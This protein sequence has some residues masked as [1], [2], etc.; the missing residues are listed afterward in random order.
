VSVVDLGDDT[1]V[2]AFTNGGGQYS[3]PYSGTVIGEYAVSTDTAGNVIFPETTI[4][5][6]M[7]ADGKL[8]V[9]A[10]NNK[11]VDALDVSSRFDLSNTSVV[12]GAYANDYY[13]GKCYLIKD[14]HPILPAGDDTSS[15]EGSS[16]EPE[17]RGEA[18]ISTNKLTALGLNSLDGKCSPS[19]AV[20][21]TDSAFKVSNS[22]GDGSYAGGGYIVGTKY[23]D[24][25]KGFTLTWTMGDGGYNC[26]NKTDSTWRD[27]ASG[28][29]AP[30][31]SVVRIGDLAIIAT[32]GH[33]KDNA[34]YGW[35]NPYQ[36]NSK[37][38]LVRMEE[39]NDTNVVL[40][41]PTGWNDNL[42]VSG[43]LL[44]SAD[45]KGDGVNFPV[46]PFYANP[47]TEYKL[48]V[49]AD[50]KLTLYINGTKTFDNID[51]GM[52]FANVNF[53]MSAFSG[54]SG[55]VNFADFDL[56]AV[57]A[58]GGSGSG[59]SNVDS[60]DNSQAVAFLVVA[61]VSGGALLILNKKKAAC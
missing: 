23:F 12:V 19:N 5:V 27:A 7:T 55:G 33:G 59:G 4:T 8:T 39:K 29:V 54:Y 30:Y 56:K 51:S 53:G 46:S 10:G 49:A 15:G 13:W 42:G 6:A 31:N 35:P 57:G 60:G 20:M 58:A 47:M 61:I 26:Y 11:V 2:S 9:T 17:I 1:N 38:M 36:T 41:G 40:K 25:S 44:A 43:T 28:V 16:S 34:P 24:L 50:G 52:S 18:P 3:T 21:L 48:V 32:R 22:S 37:Y 14:F 45:A